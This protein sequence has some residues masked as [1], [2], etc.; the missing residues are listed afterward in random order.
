MVAYQ[1]GEAEAFEILYDRYAPR[2]MGFLRARVKGD[3]QDIFQATFLKLHR[4]R[5]RYDPSFPFLPWLFTICRS[6][7]L[8]ALKKRHRAEEKLV[9]NVPEFPQMHTEL[10]EVSLAPL[11]AA[12]R[13]AVDLRY[14]SDLSFDEIA[15][16]LDT[17]PAN[18]RQLVSRA[19][20]LLRGI[21]GK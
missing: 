19:L 8:D 17:S 15:A 12:Q 6:E 20:R 9:D 4:T 2:V 13:A 14:G 21:H 11:P 16:R 18:A 5:S 3:A 7:M 10:P 1:L